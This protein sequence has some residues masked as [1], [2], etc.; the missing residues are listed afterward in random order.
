MFGQRNNSL[1]IDYWM[2]FKYGLQYNVNYTF[3]V[4]VWTKDNPFK[5]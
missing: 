3:V 1:I 4:D 2:R 5:P